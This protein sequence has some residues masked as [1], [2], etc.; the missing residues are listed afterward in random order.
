MKKTLNNILKTVAII[1]IVGVYSFI[2]YNLVAP[3]YKRHIR[4][5]QA[6]LYF[7][8]F[9]IDKNKKISID[10]FYEKYPK[11]LYK[12][13]VPFNEYDLNQD[14]VIDSNEFVKVFPGRDN[15]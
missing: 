4:L 5:E 7:K 13:H 8:N 11:K 9:D 15:F 14:N 2:F 12:N 6:E 1:G 10:E 3:I